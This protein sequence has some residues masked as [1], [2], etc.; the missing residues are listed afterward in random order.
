[1]SG[2]SFIARFREFGSVAID[3]WHAMHGCLVDSPGL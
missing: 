3:G 1:M 2:S